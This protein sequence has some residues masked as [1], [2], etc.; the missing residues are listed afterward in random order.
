MLDRVTDRL[1]SEAQPPARFDESRRLIAAASQRMP[2]GVSSN[3]R[4]GMV[5]TPLVFE[6]A[7]GPYLF[8]V[9]G[10]RLIDYYLGMGPMIL[11]HNAEPVRRAA[12]TQLE[13]GFLYGGQSRLEAEAAEL[14]CSL[15]P[16]AEKLRF[17]GSGSEAVQA[18]LRLARA[19]TGRSTV[20]KFE[21]HYHGW[22]DSI[23]VSVAATPANAG[24]AAHPNRNPGSTGQDASAWGHVDVLTW[25]DLAAV[26]ARLARGDVA[27]V[28]MEPAMC[29]AGA[30]LPH[31]GY[32]EGVREAC[33]RA[34]TVLIFDEVITG[35]RVAPGGAQ[36]RLG[37]TPDLATFAKAVA[38]GFPVAAVAG[39]AALLD[40]FATGG[41]VHG[42]TYNA[43]PIC[44]AATVATLKALADGRVMAGI[45]TQGRRL[46]EGIATH[47]KAAG[48]VATVTGFPQIFHV[49]FGL[50][51]PAED[52]RDLMR[53]DRARYIKFCGALLERRVRVLERGAWFLSSTHDSLV[54]D[55]TLAAVAQAAAEVA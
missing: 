28:I 36:Q 54:V 48:I 30:I 52:Y 40:I 29:N 50:E 37:V 46:M 6:R 5:P 47:L 42:G 23:L 11:G 22:F 45:E 9:D 24:D 10:N 27:A 31:P 3:F 15:V 12:M 2:A 32:L 41:A 13:K 21:G 25:N 44:M 43:Q 35:F 14:F 51:K 55:E 18:A 26:Q 7:E 4:T 16:C 39:K 20:V 1:N 38:N 17:C 19:A 34:G 33:D 8:D 53:M 49:A